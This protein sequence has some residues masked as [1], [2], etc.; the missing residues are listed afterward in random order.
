MKQPDKPL[1][2]HIQVSLHR[3]GA[4]V[5]GVRIASTRPQLAQRLM[6]GRT[7]EKAAELGREDAPQKP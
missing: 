4:T 5:T 2:G 3:Q 1:E 6:A 7:P